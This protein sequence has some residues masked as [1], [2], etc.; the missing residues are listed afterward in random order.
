MAE[1]FT[2]PTL[3]QTMEEGT[4]LQWFKQEGDNVKK[5]EV[6]LEVMSDKAN[7]EVEAPTDG[8]LRK[9]LVPVNDSV[10]VNTPIAIFGT[11]SEPIDAPVSAP[12][13]AAAPAPTPPPKS[14]V[15]GGVGDGAPTAPG[16]EPG[17]GAARVFL[18][19]RA[20]R[21]ADER[22]VPVSAL[23]G[24]GTG[25]EGRVV[26][27]D[28]ITYLEQ[29]AASATQEGAA[30]PRVT[31]LAARIAEELGVQIEELATGLPGSRV[32]AEDVRRVAAPTPTPPPELAE[33]PQVGAGPAVAS[34]I[35]YRGL[36]K[37]SG[38][39][40]AKSRQTA[41]HI[42]LTMEVDMTEAMELFNRLRPEIQKTYDT[43][44]TLTDILVKAVARALAD[45]P[46]CNAALIGEEIRLYADRN[47]GVAVATENGLIVPVIKRADSKSLG[48]ISVE[49]KALA[50]RCRA[51]K[52]T[53]EDISGGTFTITNL[54]AFGIDVFDPILV[55][56]QS[57]ILG[58]T[59]VADRPV[60]VN[61]EVVAR[62]MMNLCLSFDHRVLDGVPGARFL[63]RLKELLE[64]PLLIFL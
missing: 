11:A 46:L 15:A 50:E 59:R 35:P 38:E 10:P 22:G 13:G 28:V 19:P 31:P 45:H 44:L 9:I 3:G 17:V 1:Y 23:A 47:I 21:L 55:P 58:V 61:R 26:E 48:E 54:G 33:G 32:M 27:R 6:L 14:A 53:Q 64:S 42:T 60:V 24:L 43:K 30:R 12:A 5:G 40:V 25:P 36:K 20:R 34:V 16:S 39:T 8:V 29:Q 2:M 56:P 52:Q 49:L 62:S 4:I 37:M 57:C 63:Q 41:P 7:F 51:G 18:S